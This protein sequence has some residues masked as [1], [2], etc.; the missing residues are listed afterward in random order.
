MHRRSPYRHAYSGLTAWAAVA[1]AVV[2]GFA[3]LSYGLL[4]PALRA[5]LHGSYGL[6]GLVGTVNF[7]GYLLGTLAIPFVVARS[8]ERVQLNTRCLFAMSAAMVGS[9]TSLD[10]VQLG[11]WRLLIGLFSAPATVL[12]IALT[13]ERVAPAERGRAAGMIWMGGAASVVVSGL[14]APLVAG[15]GAA[16]AWRAAWVGMGLMGLVATWGLRRALRASV[17][18]SGE[19]GDEE[20]VPRADLDVP[21]K[22]GRLVEAQRHGASARIAGQAG[23]RPTLRRLLHPRG[24]LALT[25]AYLAFGCG[26][27]IYFTFFIALVVQQGVPALLVGLVWSALGLVGAAGGL[28][29]GWAI[30]RWP[31]GVTLA[32]ALALGALGALGVGGLA[33]D[34]AGALL[35]GLCFLGTPT[36][37]TVLLQR[38]VPAARYTASLSVLTAAFALGQMIGPSIGG[39]VADAHGLALGTATAAPLLASAALLAVGYG[40]VQRRQRRPT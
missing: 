27:I 13:L 16:P 29:W 19:A 25:L 26:Y 9:A 40:L 35:M 1:F 23:L 17:P 2:L 8:R 20:A 32:V 6:F 14:V 24:L 33:L 31:S 18:P 36:M 15:T 4:L 34:G 10:L 30:D 11:A 5:D 12:T 3:R 7:G 37:V 38:A 28:L 22:T 21:G 39:V